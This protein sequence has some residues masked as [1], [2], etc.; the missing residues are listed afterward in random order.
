MSDDVYRRLAQHLDKLPNG[1]PATESG[2]EIRILKHLFSPADAELALHLKP[3]L[4]RAGAIGQ[5]AGLDEDEA[6]ERLRDLAARGLIFSI[7]SGDRPAMFIAAPFVVGIWEY[8]VNRLTPELV[9]EANEY[10]PQLGRVAFDVLP[11]L[12]TIPVGKSLEPDLEVMV[13]ERA[14]EMVRAQD[15]FLVAPCICR[16]EHQMAGDWCGKMIES[17]LV[18]GWGVSIT[19]CATAS[20]GR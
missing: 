1:Y 17:C 10:F 18:F 3:K 16:K 14:E 4:E 2:V 8:N 6:L 15:R 12:R 20:A 5:R 19:T 9:A 11:Q 13:Y 7:D